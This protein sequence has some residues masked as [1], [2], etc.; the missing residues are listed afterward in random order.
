MKTVMSDAFKKAEE[1]KK[2]DG[3]GSIPLNLDE[4]QVEVLTD[5]ELEQKTQRVQ[6]RRQYAEAA[7]QKIA[8]IQREINKLKRLALHG[9]LLDEDNK[10]LENLEKTKKK[11]LESGDEELRKHLNFALFIEEIREAEQEKNIAKIFLERVVAEGRYRLATE[12]E[13]NQIRHDK[14][15]PQG[16]V[17][18]G[19]KV[20][21]PAFSEEEKSSGQRAIESELGKYIREVNKMLVKERK[22]KTD[23]IKSI[24]VKNLAL[25]KQGEAGL[26]RLEFQERE[27]ET[28]RKW[29]AGIGLIEL[30]NNSNGDK[31]FLVIMVKKGT[32]SLEWFNKYTEKWIP[33]SWY[34]R[35]E[36]PETAPD[37]EFAEK[38]IKT[39]RAALAAH[40]STK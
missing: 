37:P 21:L 29:R 40:Y 8:T 14:K 17:F 2:N 22:S 11:I 12:E 20:Y 24:T 6:E 18:F 7:A 38:L 36:I 15:W 23:E 5:E 4:I 31:S 10:K 9:V 30:R 19:G 27:D 3:N 26:Y 25:F 13:T 28:G 32:G 34:K 33:Y 39:I 35:D 1:K 16:T